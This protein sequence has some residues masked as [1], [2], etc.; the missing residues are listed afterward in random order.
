MSVPAFSEGE[1]AKKMAGLLGALLLVLTGCVQQSADWEIQLAQPGSPLEAADA[2]LNPVSNG[3]YRRTDAQSAGG[4]GDMT[5]NSQNLLNPVDSVFGPSTLPAAPSKY[6]PRSS[7]LDEARTLRPSLAVPSYLPNGFE[8]V[9]VTVRDW[10]SIVRGP[11]VDMV[12]KHPEGALIEISQGGAAKPGGLDV[13][14]GSYEQVTFSGGAKSGYLVRGSW[15]VMTTA[16]GVTTGP[17]W[18]SDLE[19]ELVFED[20]GTLYVLRAVNS[21]ILLPI[22]SNE[23]IRVAESMLP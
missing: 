7:S 20:S 17:E 6:Q 1:M 23:L 13:K 3:S 11:V 16:D 4:T 19:M 18:N 22:S 5:T 21:K 9:S 2:G 10:K 8:L 14:T 15:I 12:Y